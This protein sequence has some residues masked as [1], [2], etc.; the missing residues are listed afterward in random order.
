MI[1]AENELGLMI[2]LALV[3]VVAAFGLYFFYKD[4]RMIGLLT[5]LIWLIRGV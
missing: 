2:S 4:V 1:M 5:I 3:G